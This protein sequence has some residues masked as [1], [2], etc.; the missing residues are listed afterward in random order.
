LV[1]VIVFF[2]LQSLFGGKGSKVYAQAQASDKSAS[3]TK[4]TRRPAAKT[5]LTKKEKPVKKAGSTRSS[6]LKKKVELGP[7]QEATVIIDGAIVYKSA[8]FDAPMINY[9]REGQ[10]IQVSQKVYGPFYRVAMSPTTIGYISDVD[11]KVKGREFL[12]GGANKSMDRDEDNTDVAVNLRPILETVY[13]GVGYGS[14]YYTE[15]LGGQEPIDILT[16]YSLKATGPGM[17]LD[18]PFTV[19]FSMK[20]FNKVPE[21]YSLLS[22]TVPEGLGVYAD[23]V[24]VLPFAEWNWGALYYG[25][26]MELL[27]TDYKI[28]RDNTSLSMKEA[29]LGFVGLL[30]LALRWSGLVL[31]AETKGYYDQ[32][33]YGGW[34]I[35]LQYAIR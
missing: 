5:P 2:F 1:L 17:V 13:F 31:K 23:T 27:Y 35:S 15:P 22:S 14:L 24:I 20:I 18:G 12:A 26:G 10:T 30:G 16:T 19:D 29:K 11:V 34:E 21:Y 6:R 7:A 32:S 4:K 28:T 3:G 33:A 8:S 9:L 25:G